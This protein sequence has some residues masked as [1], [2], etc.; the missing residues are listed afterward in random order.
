MLKRFFN[1][2]FSKKE[3]EV[4]LCNY[5]QALRTNLEW[6]KFKVVGCPRCG[7]RRVKP[8]YPNRWGRLRVWTRY[9][10]KGF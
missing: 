5:C 10:L 6:E 7:S 4:Y 3:I 2:F 8:I 1:V 9:V